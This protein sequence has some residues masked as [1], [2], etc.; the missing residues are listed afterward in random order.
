MGGLCGKASLTP[1]ERAEKEAQRRAQAQEDRRAYLRVDGPT[2]LPPPG[3]GR[4]GPP[5]RSPYNIPYQP[6]IAAAYDEPE[7][8]RIKQYPAEPNEEEAASS[9]MDSAK[10][11]QLI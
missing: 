10:N 8:S 2:F 7:E 1:E 5:D 9:Y 4:P 6:T 3:Y 11:T